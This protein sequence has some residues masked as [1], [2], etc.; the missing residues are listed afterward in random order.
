M[1]AFLILLCVGIVG[2]MWWCV[3]TDQLRETNLINLLSLM[4]N[5]ELIHIH[6]RPKR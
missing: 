5:I 1:R 4:L 2:F 3:H 6:S